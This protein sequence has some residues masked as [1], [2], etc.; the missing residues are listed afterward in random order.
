MAEPSEPTGDPLPDTALSWSAI[1]HQGRVRQNNEDAFLAL[2]FDHRELRRLGKFGEASTAIGDFVFAVSDGM[3]GHKAGE[4]ASK[5]AVEK[6]A[7]LFPRTFKLEA[8]GLLAVS[9]D[10]LDVLVDSI[11]A[12]IALLGRSYDECSNMGATLTL[13]WLR[14]GWLHF[15]HI[16]DS[17]LYYL[18]AA[19]GIRQ[20]TEDH[21]YVNLLIKRGQLTPAQARS[22]PRRNQLSKALL[23]SS[24]ATHLDPQKGSIELNQGDR[25]VLCTDGLTD[26][27]GDANIEHRLRTPP[28]HQQEIHPAFRLVEDS[29]A[30]SGRDNLTALVIEIL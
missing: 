1:T 16:G 26:G 6:I 13:A 11:Q 22:H 14:P 25:F 19:G 7:E 15:C 12:E 24:T 17:R 2:T 29:L 30:N 23:A 10:L 28:P 18:P 8:S 4:F 3:G 27:L 9:L 21:T 20:I 5:I